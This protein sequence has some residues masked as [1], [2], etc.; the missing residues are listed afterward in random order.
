MKNLEEFFSGIS[1]WAL[2]PI[3]F[4]LMREAEGFE[5]HTGKEAA[6]GPRQH[7]KVRRPQ[8]EGHL[9]PSE[10]EELASGYEKVGEGPSEKEEIEEESSGERDKEGELSAPGRGTCGHYVSEAG[11]ER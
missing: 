5:R 3:P 9:E 10:A 11:G 4:S 1:E 6:L 8:A 7:M 2:Y